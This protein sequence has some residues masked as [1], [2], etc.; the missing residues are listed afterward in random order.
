MSKGSGYLLY[1][2][3]DTMYD[4]CFPILDK[5][6][7]K[8]DS[9]EDA[10]FEG[11][12]EEIVRDISNIKQEIINYRRIV[13]PQ[14]PTLRL[15]E[16]STQRFAPAG[17]R[18]LLRRHRRQERAHLGPPGELQGGR[19]GARGD[20]RVGDRPPA[21]RR[22]PR[23]DRPL[24]V[25][26]LPLTLITGI[27]GHERRMPCRGDPTTA[28][29]SV[30]C[31]HRRHGRRRRRACSPSSAA[32][33]GCDGRRPA[34]RGPDIMWS[35]VAD[36][37]RRRPSTSGAYEGPACVFCELPAQRRR[38][39]H[40]HPAPW[41]ARV[42][43]HE[44]LPVQ[45]RAPDDGPVRARGLACATLD[46][47]TLTE[48]MDA[49]AAR[50]SR[51]S[52]SGCDPRASTSASTRGARP[53]PASP[54]TSTC[55][56][57][58]RWVGDTNFMPVARRR[59]GDAP[60]P[61]RDLRPPAAGVRGVTLDP[62]VFKAYDVRGLYPEEIDEDGRR[63]RSAGLRRRHRA[64]A[65]RG[66]PRRAPL[67]ALAWPRAS[68][69]GALAAGADVIELGLC[70]H[71]DALLRGGR[72][73]A[74]T[75]APASPPATTRPQYTGAKMVTAGAAAALGRRPASARSGRI[76]ARRPAAR[77]RARPARAATTDLLGALR[78]RVPGASSTRP[79]S[80]AC[81][82]SSTPPTAWPGLYL[83]PVLERLGIDAGAL[84]PRP[85]RPLPQP[86]AQPAA[87][88]EPRVHRSAKVREEGADLG[89]AFDGDA[90]R[91][92]FIDDTGEFVPGDFLT[93]LLAEHLLRRARARR[94]SST[95]CG[96]RGRC[97][98]PSRPRAAPPDST[99]WAT[100]SS[101]AACGS[102][103][104]SS[105]AR[106]AA[107]TT[108]GTSRY[109]DTGLIPALLVLEMVATGGAAAV[110]RWSPGFRERYH[111]S[112]EINSTVDDA[113]AAL[114]APSRA[115]RRRP[116]DRD[117]RAVGG[118]RRLALQRAP[119]QHRA[120]AAAQ[121]RV[122][123]LRGG[124]GAAPRRGARGDPL[125]V[126]GPRSVPGEARAVI[127]AE[128]LEV[129]Y[130]GGP[131]PAVRGVSLRLEP[132]E[133][134]L[135]RGPAGAGKTSLL[136]GL[137]GLVPASG[138]VRRARRSAGRRGVA[139]ARG[140]RTPGRAASRR[141]L[142]CARSCG[143]RRGPAARTRTPRGAGRRRARA[144]RARPGGRLA[145]RAASTSR[146]GGA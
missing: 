31:H 17:P 11:R 47:P 27:Y 71:R 74:T 41:R 18:A 132:G 125:R 137:L 52:R 30:F 116:P 123:G 70:G 40:L 113:A 29:W 19:G 4:Y 136:R 118:V 134:L 44:P 1:E 24:G 126:T 119:L 124:H 22:H 13:K 127:A 77:G 59:A 122:A 15:L 117:R 39:A 112:G 63:A 96:P 76:A 144:G 92:F 108:S 28:S 49:R 142:R 12:S 94:P 80:A 81:A 105:P 104:P 101:S 42:R 36:G 51:C 145:H 8:L 32:R 21:E 33:G 131:D 87:A 129:R 138:R 14:R 143:R 85:R 58:P 38:R 35:P 43:D 69:T 110:A 16:R 5:I 107:T 82:W 9:I 25:V 73:A 89:I 133:G 139:R 50:R 95:T 62:R 91:C 86:R 102:W 26:I 98:T 79:P 72:R 121:P 130:Q 37:L 88:R 67:L 78:D 56:S 140:L 68:P 75:P 61:R 23:P 66:G 65:G 99:A 135:L 34:R 83:P 55:T 100:P 57:L 45:Q 97:A 115:L 141:G 111:I 90:D 84:L 53:A 3:V 114:A 54:T 93:A 128:A 103:T 20:Q 2:I 48:M 10:I 60:A 106:S 6:G 7:F 46:E 109:A 64:P 120:A 146:A